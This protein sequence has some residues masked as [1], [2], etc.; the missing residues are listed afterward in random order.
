M[1]QL[2]RVTIRL[3]FLL[4]SGVRMSKTEVVLFIR[5]LENLRLHGEIRMYRI[6]EMCYRMKLNHVSGK[7]YMQFNTL[8]GV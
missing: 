5:L 4:L 1:Q 7:M 3:R 6:Q 2:H 8:M